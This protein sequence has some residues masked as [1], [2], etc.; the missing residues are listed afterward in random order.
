MNDA[1]LATVTANVER[2]FAKLAKEENGYKF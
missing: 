1:V 2:D